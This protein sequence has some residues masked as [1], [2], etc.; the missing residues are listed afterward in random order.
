M[1]RQRAKGTAAETA[2]VNYL[3][4]AGFPHA[5]RR[6]TNGAHDR[7][8]IA[9]VLGTVIEVKNCARVELAAWIDEA[10]RETANDGAAIGA[11]WHKRKGTTSPG[12]WYVTTDGDTFAVLLRAYL[13]IDWPVT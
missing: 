6:A 4:T 3:R 12:K 2:L 9:G 8:D 13:G 11:V 10:R 5:E 7:G 1:S